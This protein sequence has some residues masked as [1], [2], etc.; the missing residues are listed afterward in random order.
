MATSKFK[1]GDVVTVSSRA[2]DARY[3][4]I[5]FKYVQGISGVKYTVARVLIDKHLR[6]V[7]RVSY[8][9]IEL[10]LM[11]WENELEKATELNSDELAEFLEK[12]S[13]KYG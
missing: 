1:V 11:F 12:E 7:Y 8:D 9:G 3:D 5:R 10:P 2:L 13:I 4:A 6:H